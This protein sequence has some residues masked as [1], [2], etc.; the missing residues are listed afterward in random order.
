MPELL[1]LNT[2]SRLLEG[3]LITLEISAVSIIISSVGGLFM[4]VIYNLKNPFINAFCRFCLEFVRVMPLIVWLF[5]IYFGLSRW[6]GLNLSAVSAAI[7]VFSI[8]GVFEMMDLVRAALQSIPKHQYESAASLALNTYELYTF[9]ILPQ[10][11]RRLTPA[12]INLLTRM[13]KSTTFAFLIGAV[14]LV[15]VGQQIIEFHH[16]NVYASFV[17]YGIIFFIYFLLCYPLSWYSQIL[18]KKWS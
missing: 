8:W 12:S 5:V 13:I 18:E 7:L 4:G 15:K 3:L 6:F 10:A 9:V 2:F 14:E 17:I 11:L 1:T 16:S